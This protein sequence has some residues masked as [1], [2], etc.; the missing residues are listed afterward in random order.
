MYL[1]RLEEDTKLGG[2]KDDSGSGRN[3]KRGANIIKIHCMK[4]FCALSGLTSKSE[5]D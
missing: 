5:R 2:E 4:L 3:R 1:K